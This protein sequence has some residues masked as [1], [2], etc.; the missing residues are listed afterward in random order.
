MAVHVENETDLTFDFPLEGLLTE[1]VECALDTEEFPYEAEVNIVLTNDEE[2][3]A[4]N[5]ESRGIDAAT[6]VLSFPALEYEAAGDFSF[7]E[8]LS[9]AEELNYCNPETGE[10]ILGDMMI[11]LEHVKAQAKEYGHSERRELA[12]LCVHSMLHLFG[13]DHIL[14][15]D[16]RLMQEEEKRILGRLGI[17][18]A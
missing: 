13:Y 5:Q 7:L 1:V 12:F 11:S 18:R 14:E 2:I 6:D 15:S 9:D 17:P 8:H 16:R 3:R 4:I 10:L